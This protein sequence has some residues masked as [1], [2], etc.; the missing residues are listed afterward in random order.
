V[1]VGSIHG[2]TRYNSVPPEVTLQVTT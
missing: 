2:G 1:T